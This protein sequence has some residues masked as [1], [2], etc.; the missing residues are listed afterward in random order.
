[1]RTVWKFIGETSKL[2][3]INYQSL[4]TIKIEYVNRVKLIKR[5]KHVSNGN[6]L[7]IRIKLNYNGEC[8]QLNVNICNIMATI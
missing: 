7:R 1:M 8:M 4:I 3:G 5:I 6:S 2:N